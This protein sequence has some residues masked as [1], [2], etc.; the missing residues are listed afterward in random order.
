M[1]TRNLAIAFASI[2]DYAER[3]SGKTWEQSQRML[4]V[5]PALFDPVARAYGGRRVK[6]VGGTFLYAFESPTRAVLCGAALQERARKYS[7]QADV[8]R[9][10]VGIHLGEVRVE[11]GDVFGEP[12]NIA[13]RLEALALPGEVLFG[14]SC[15]LSMSRGEVRAE[16]QG[17]RELKGVPE[18]VRV[19][20]LSAPLVPLLS[21]GELPHPE[22]EELPGELGVHLR[23]AGQVALLHVQG[24][25]PAR[26]RVFLGASLVAMAAVGAAFF[27]LARL[28]RLP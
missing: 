18:P 2:C 1:R 6:Q 26:L 22:A 23:A 19:F 28:G 3:F 13:A 25:W 7:E 11:R 5:L 17:P 20:R 21:G 16:D 9:V 8:L 12:V 24:A 10:R 14:E 15:W 27:A 4:R